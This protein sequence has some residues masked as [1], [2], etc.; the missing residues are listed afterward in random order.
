MKKQILSEEFKHMQK[1]AGIINE[2]ESAAPLP[3]E[4]WTSL[5]QDFEFEEDQ[6]SYTDGTSDPYYQYIYYGIIFSPEEDKDKT[7]SAEIQYNDYSKKEWKI[8]DK[9]IDELMVILDNNGYE[10][11]VMEYSWKIDFTIS[12]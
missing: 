3:P 11:E 1:I 8:I 9:K 10:Y 4:K 5:G 6:Q 2:N 12:F 7:L